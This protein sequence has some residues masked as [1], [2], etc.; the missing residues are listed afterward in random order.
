[1]SIYEY[2]NTYNIPLSSTQK[3][4][5][6]KIENPPET[7]TTNNMKDF[8]NSQATINNSPYFLLNDVSN[9]SN[10]Y[11]YKNEQTGT[12]T[13]TSL[14]WLNS[15][16]ECSGDGCFKEDPSNKYNYGV[17]T[18][19]FSLYSKTQKYTYKT[20]DEYNKQFNTIY[21][22]LLTNLEEFKNIYKN[23]REIWYDCVYIND[24]KVKIK[25][26]GCFH[27][28][29][30]YTIALELYTEKKSQV[31]NLLSQLLNMRIL[32][33]NKLSVINGDIV[34]NLNQLE[35]MDKKINTIR[36]YLNKLME[37]SSGAIGMLKDS[38]YNSTVLIT[39][40]TVMSIIIIGLVYFYFSQKQ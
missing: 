30:E 34:Y 19:N 22:D 18:D 6:I 12:G 3:T 14:T 36:E 9:I 10:C 37:D 16:D 7:A 4:S 31:N 24:N 25:D 8:C 15:L 35:I 38:K 33:E 17:G 11:I 20:A 2:K 1:M 32:I 40:N 29:E 39:E 27:T 23:Y 26:I 13:G 21:N 5:L 28:R